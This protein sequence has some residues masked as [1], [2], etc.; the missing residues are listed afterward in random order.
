MRSWLLILVCGVLA[1]GEA[2][3]SGTVVDRPVRFVNDQVLTIGDIRSRNGIRVELFRRAGRVL[4]DSRDGLLRFNRDTLEE[5]TDEELLVQKADELKVSIDRDR[6]SSDVIAEARQRGL[7]LRDIATLR[8]VRHREAKVD[9]VLGWFES[10][11]SSITP[12]EQRAAYDN[13]LADFAR[14]PRARTLLIA[15][16]PTADDERR[17]LVKGLAGLMREA[18]QSDDAAI[19]AAAAGQLDAFLAADSAGQEVILARVA[20]E[21]AKSAGL[22]KNALAQ[23]ASGLLTRWRAV[24]S[25]EQCLD[26]L[27]ALRDGLMRLEAPARAEPFSAWAKAHSQGPQAAEGG[28]LGWVEPKTFGKDIE[29]QALAMPVGE[30]SAP[31]WTGGAAAV[32]LVLEREEGRT[33]SFAEVSATLQAALERDRRQQVRN[34]VTAVLRSQASIRDVV[35]LGQLIQ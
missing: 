29:D 21:V 3:T 6:L 32:V 31:F 11:S 10:R 17:E 13:H 20:D 28:L 27:N 1:A 18:Q 23:R 26:E 14:P 9:A 16:R 19:S 22:G 24:R 25:R 33:Q 7:A 35:D 30:P 4:P 5:L 8:R 2:E 12:S 34:R 15:L